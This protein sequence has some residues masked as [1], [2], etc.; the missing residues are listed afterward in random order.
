[1]IDRFDEILQNLG[2]V[3]DLD[4]RAD[5]NHACAIQIKQGLIV[6]LQCDAAQ[7]NLLIASKVVELPPGKFRENVLKEALKANAK[8]DPIV[9]I[10]AYIAKINQLVLFQQ[11]P[12]DVLTSE[13][14][15]GLLGPF[16]QTAEKWK[17]AILAGQPAP[18]PSEI[19]SLY[20]M[21]GLRP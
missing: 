9:G 2:K 18:P 4:L 5:R 1:M 12:F 20:A 17:N 11:Y 13:R 15:A 10:F 3:F 14:L 19:S 16:I 21:K 7:E 6:Q 8:L